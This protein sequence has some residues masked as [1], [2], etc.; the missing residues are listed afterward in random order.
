MRI[1][2]V[3]L[4]PEMFQ[5]PFAASMLARAQAQGAVEIGMVP[6][7]PFGV[8]VHRITDDYPYGGGAGMLMRPEPLVEAVEW[9]MARVPHPARVIVSSAQGR[10]LTQPMLEE[11]A[12]LPYVIMIAGH[13]EG[14]DQRVI[15][16]LEADEVSLGS[17]VLTGG[18]LPVMVMVDG[19]VR[20]LPGV[21]GAE[22]GTATDSF[23]GEDRLL[24]GPQYTRPISYRGREVP[25]VLRSG[26]HAEIARWRRRE[27]ERVTETVRPDLRRLWNAERG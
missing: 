15:D 21:L 14:I 26:N 23:S 10:L 12:K 16:I 2:I 9:A 17:F 27:A 11:W 18:E 20:L 5:G 1:D 24:E 8:G 25:A 6:L 4:F 19:V 13:Y 3:T 22:M 7:R